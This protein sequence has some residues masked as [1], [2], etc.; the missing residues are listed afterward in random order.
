MRRRGA[1]NRA[2]SASAAFTL[3]EL[4]VVIGIITVLIAIL[5]PAIQT[6]RAQ[7]YQVKC[8]AN[9]RSIGQGM[10]TYVHDYKH[11]PA[12]YDSI[13]NRLA[14]IWVT[15]LRKGTGRN[16]DVFHCP[17]RPAEYRW[18]SEFGPPGQIVP[19][20]FDPGSETEYADERFAAYGFELGERVASGTYDPF[21]Y[22][23]N[24]A[25]CNVFMRNN[26]SNGLGLGMR[27]RHGSKGS[28]DKLNVLV[29]ERRASTVRKPAEMVA[30]GDSGD[31]NYPTVSHYDFGIA[32]PRPEHR[33]LLHN[34]NVGNL[35]RGGANILF[36]D[37]HVQWFKHEDL[38]VD[39][40]GKGLRNAAMWNFDN[41][42]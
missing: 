29:H 3:V 26:T 12:L 20:V 15:R 1:D 4:L 8:A 10:A 21:S 7:A 32:A 22:G 30:V 23:Y 16:M 40:S 36:C 25:G 18:K 42:P 17:S 24:A 19:I 14:P 41:Q 31:S 35:H 2:A 9:L 39:T 27:A 38:M 13:S 5:L 6:A 28:L 33:N 11:Y 37:G 34:G